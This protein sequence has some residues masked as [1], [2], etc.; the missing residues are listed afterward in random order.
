MHL[1]GQ[2]LHLCVGLVAFAGQGRD[3]CLDL[4]YIS[5]DLAP[6]IAT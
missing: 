4:G 3:L 2:R 6:F 1:T 5:I